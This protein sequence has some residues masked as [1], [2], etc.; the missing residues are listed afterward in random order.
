MQPKEKKEV[1]AIVRHDGVSFR[2]WAP[3]ADSVC[4]TGSFN[5]WTETPLASEDDGYWY[6]F[7]DNAKAGQEYK[8][9]I[10]RGEQVLH[11]NDPRALAVTTLAGNSVIVDPAFDWG[12]DHPVAIPP[13]QQV[14]YE[15]HVGTFNR[16]DPATPGTFATAMEKLDYLKEL[17]ITTIE[18]M[19]IGNMYM[20][21]EWWGYTP[22]Y[23]YAVENLYGGRHQLLEF[24][25]A[26][27]ARGLA[28]MLDVVY[29]HF[30]DDANLDLWQY[31]G[32]SE[33][34]MGGVYFYNDERGVTPWGKTRPDYGR[35]EV[36]QFL[37]DNVRLWLWDC[38]FDGLRV[39]STIYIRTTSGINDDPAHELE[40]GWLFL[41]RLNG[42]A[43][44]L[45]PN[46]LIVAEDIACNE[47]LSKPVADGGAGFAGQWEVD[48]PDM[49]R[50]TLHTNEPSAIPLAGLIGSLGKRYNDDA[51]QRVVY[52]DSHDS[53]ANGS[54]RFN[55]VVAGSKKVPA[56]GVFARR[57][58]CIAAAIV[59]SAPGIPMLFMG[60]EFLEDG[61]FSDWE[62]LDWAKTAKHAG[63]LEAYRHLIAL[64][65]NLHGHT[66]GLSGQHYNLTQ[67]DEDN[68]VIAYHRWHEG[69]PKDDVM[70]IVNLGNRHFDS[71]VLGFPRDGSWQVRF[72]STWDGYSK[73][74]ANVLV[75][76]VQVMTGE[77]VVV[78][79]PSSVLIL[80]Q[81][82]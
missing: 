54:A 79:P 61:S 9:V 24:I 27:H 63:I 64:R 56:T 74:F 26:A 70:V 53:A 77:G 65:R 14:I 66:A 38:H 25:K 68:K 45:N 52:A 17:G 75:P 60:Q 81:D 19:P 6:G 49:L 39:D 50:H 15:L 16:P 29:N 40:D 32:W 76:E 31:D 59:L 73:D 41:Q 2:V 69:G 78:V 12:D 4:L 23:I 46:A 55:D 5:E 48:F 35:P 58:S 36:R 43:R 57:Q 10:R 42:L 28:V 71:Y 11:R 82:A 80:S 44:K 7:V 8:F 37:L 21:R 62:C 51:F 72:N 20:Q 3:F 34:N 1:G 33:H 18:L 22:E 67:L 47:Y 30:A 13:E